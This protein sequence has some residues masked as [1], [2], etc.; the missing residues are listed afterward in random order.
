LNA[1]L[2][3]SDRLRARRCTKGISSVI[4]PAAITVSTA[5]FSPRHRRSWTVQ[6]FFRR[7]SP[8][9]TLRPT[10]GDHITK[11]EFLADLE[12]VVLMARP[13]DGRVLGAQGHAL[14]RPADTATLGLRP[15]PARQPLTA[16]HSAP[17]PGHRLLG[18]RPPNAGRPYAVPATRNRRPVRRSAPAHCAPPCR[19]GTARPFCGLRRH[20]IGDAATDGRAAGTRISNCSFTPPCNAAAGKGPRAT[21]ASCRSSSSPSGHPG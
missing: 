19:P 11:I 7:R 8:Q 16:V 21:S 17:L 9:Q 6:D 13:L 20:P 2:L 15:P 5:Q 3:H 10:C 4:A 1:V 14:E 12:Q 18:L